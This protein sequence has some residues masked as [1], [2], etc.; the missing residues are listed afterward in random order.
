MI[1]QRINEIP[2]LASGVSSNACAKSVSS[3]APVAAAPVQNIHIS[4]YSNRPSR[5]GRRYWRVGQFVHGLL[6]RINIFNNTVIDCP[7]EGGGERVL[8]GRTICPRAP[9]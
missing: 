5:E 7:G 8:E 4:Q 2:T 6:H 3:T 9:T 1:Q